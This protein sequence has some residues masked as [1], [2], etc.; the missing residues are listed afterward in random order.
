MLE[1]YYKQD[2]ILPL[3]QLDC[4]KIFFTWQQSWLDNILFIVVSAAE[5][6]CAAM[7]RNLHKKLM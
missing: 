5:Q 1:S 4:Q 3:V 2:S 7:V 6:K